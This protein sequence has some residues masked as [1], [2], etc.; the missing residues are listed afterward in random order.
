M[1]SIAV[2][3]NSMQRNENTMVYCLAGRMERTGTD[4]NN[5]PYNKNP[6]DNKKPSM[7]TVA[8]A[9]LFH[10]KRLFGGRRHTGRPRN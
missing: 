2:K 10:G 8:L 6:S 3:R 7:R 5:L 4:T 9:R 1:Q